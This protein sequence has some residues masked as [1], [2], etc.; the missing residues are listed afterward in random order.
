MGSSKSKQTVWQEWRELVNMAP[1][2][3]SQWL[4][5]DESQ[6]VGVD[7][8]EGESIGHQS[9]ERIVDILRTNKDSLTE[10]DWDHMAKVIGYIK[11]HTAQGGPDDGVEHSP[12]R[13]SLMNWGHDPMKA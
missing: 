13:Y 3:L 2:E 11:R 9:G 12:W 10:D 4:Q 1:K 7:S 6:S 8:G 5:T